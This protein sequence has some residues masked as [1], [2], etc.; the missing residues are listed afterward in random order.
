[1]Q[2]LSV[3]GYS[4][5]VSRLHIVG[6]MVGLYT[7]TFGRLMVTD[8][9]TWGTAADGLCELTWLT[10][11]SQMWE[12]RVHSSHVL[13]VYSRV[14]PDCS[15]PKVRC[16]LAGS[17]TLAYLSY[18]RAYA[19]T[20]KNKWVAGVL[21]TICVV[22]FGVGVYMFIWAILNPAVTL[23]IPLDSYRVCL[24]KTTK[25][26][27]VI[28]M[29]LSLAFGRYPSLFLIPFLGLTHLLVPSDMA[30]FTLVVVQTRFL[31]SMHR[32]V[33]VPSIID[34]VSRDAEIYFAVITTT[35]FLIVVMYAAA[36]VGVLCVG[37]QAWRALTIE[38]AFAARGRVHT[39][40]VSRPY[41]CDCAESGF[42]N[43]LPSAGETRCEMISARIIT[44]AR[45]A[46]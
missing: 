40:S 15:D 8:R 37:T 20:G 31:K 11:A 3:L 30:V 41:A 45:M 44:D 33:N 23:G 32:G 46:N 18:N 27:T 43:C 10:L 13:H 26:F 5:V 1:M 38:S 9:R 36:R 22:Q 12:D 17:D 16:L 42:A 35:H 19:I 14:C 7:P 4:D 34:T 6:G 28:Q 21:Y 25:T 24:A 29:A 39:Y 2:T